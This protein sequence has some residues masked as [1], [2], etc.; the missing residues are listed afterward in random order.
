MQTI[1]TGVQT[2]AR[3]SYAPGIN[4][5]LTLRCNG[6]E[7]TQIIDAQGN[8][9]QAG[10]PSPSV[11]P[12][13]TV[14][15]DGG[16]GG[17]GIYR[18]ANP[19]A[20]SG[21]TL[22]C[23]I[24]YVYVAGVNYPFVQSSVGGGGDLAPRSNPSVAVSSPTTTVLA[25]T[26]FGYFSATC[27]YSTRSDITEIWVYRTIYF[28]DGPDGLIYGATL[29]A[30]YQMFFVKSVPNN[31]AG[32]TVKIAVNIPEA[33]ILGSGEVE[34]DNQVAPTA[35]MCVF[36]NPYFYLFGNNPLICYGALTQ[37]APVPVFN[38]ADGT[39]LYNGRNGQS[40]KFDGLTTGGYDGLGSFYLKYISPS[41]FSLYLDSTLV[42][43]APTTTVTT[44][45]NT[46]ATI[47]GFSSVLYRSKA[48]NPLA[49]GETVLVNQAAIPE[50][51]KLNIG[52]KGTSIC[53]IPAASLLRLDTESPTKSYTLNL[54]VAEL[55]IFRST[56]RTIS[57]DHS[58]SVN[59]T[60]FVATMRDGSNQIW[61][62]DLKSYAILQSDGTQNIPI[63]ERV[64]Q[65]LR[66]LSLV[67]S[68]QIRYTGI[69]DKFT[70]L[71]CIWVKFL[72]HDGPNNLLIYQHAPSGE[73]GMS[74]EHDLTTVG[75]FTNPYTEEQIILGGTSI[76]DLG[77]IFDPSQ[78]I[79]K[80]W[81]ENTNNVVSVNIVTGLHISGTAVLSGSLPSGDI[82]GRWALV[83]F[84]KSG[85]DYFYGHISNV[86]TI[87]IT[88]DRIYY[89][90]GTSLFT[91]VSPPN[92]TCHLYVGEIDIVLTK[93]FDLMQATPLKSIKELWT[94]LQK[95]TTQAEVFKVGFQ[96]DLNSA[97]QQL[98]VPTTL[99]NQDYILP[100]NLIALTKFRT[101]G[102][103]LF[104]RGYSTSIF[105]NIT[106]IFNS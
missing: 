45:L 89:P 4:V 54:R 37:I 26:Q 36:A 102:I 59:G 50:L 42:T 62:L 18:E 11:A 32:G 84:D 13:V 8:I 49:W 78:N 10:I 27:A 60:S 61:S 76:G 52:G 38:I 30:A 67:N 43:P 46:T 20:V 105:Q 94:T 7:Q 1:A 75:S 57:E 6:E 66:M 19:P 64:K 56:L 34:L 93:Y 68:D 103:D 70:E 14:N 90:F 21:A 51:W 58:T 35:L 55:D 23:Y 41:S 72:H 48:N 95:F 96:P 44:V 81:S 86:V 5:D 31:T 82:L 65:T 98:Q 63:S 39:I 97:P 104:E 88:F 25:D 74:W 40:V 73:W 3:T 101:M 29:G 106:L 91:S 69:Y 22:R 99:N 2:R 28:S 15:T 92:N 17:I 71:N 47:Y 24:A 53:I 12:V 33:V 9:Q 85:G 80:N 87:T 79:C 16:G 100:G 83:E 77:R